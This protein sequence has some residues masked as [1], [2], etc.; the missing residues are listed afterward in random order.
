MKFDQQIA[1]GYD[2]VVVF[3]MPISSIGMCAVTIMSLP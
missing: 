3:V 1:A 2:R